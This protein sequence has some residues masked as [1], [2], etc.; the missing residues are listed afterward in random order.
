MARSTRPL[1]PSEANLVLALL[2]IQKK[3]L[4]TTGVRRAKTQLSSNQGHHL[5]DECSR[6]SSQKDAGF[7]EP[8][9]SADRVS[10]ASK[11]KLVCNTC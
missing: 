3:L 8:R 2:L 1:C 11:R 7:K 10:Q 4:N 9:L 6:L 5:R